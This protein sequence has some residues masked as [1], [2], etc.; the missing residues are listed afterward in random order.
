M[1][2]LGIGNLGA[3]DMFS[4]SVDADDVLEYVPGVNETLLDG[5]SG[6][7]SS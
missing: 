5:N 6:L 3:G 2:R 7:G 4:L 1:E